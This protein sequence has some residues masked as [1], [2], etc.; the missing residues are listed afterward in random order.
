MLALLKE[1]WFIIVIV[2][3]GLFLGVYMYGCE[4]KVASII[5]DGRYVNR[6][7]LQFELDK[8]I[9]LAQ[10]RMLD[11]DKQEQFRAIVLENALVLVQGQ[12]LNPVGILTALAGLYGAGQLTNSGVKVVKT[13][14]KKRKANNGQT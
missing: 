2:F 12:P 3:V 4:P 11:L 7:E 1:K 14:C 9:N 8:V 10:L 13:A 5:N 6:R